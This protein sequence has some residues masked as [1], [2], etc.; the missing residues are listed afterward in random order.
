M[1]LAEA[2]RELTQTGELRP[3]ARRAITRFIEQ[4]DHWENMGRMMDHA[5]LAQIILDES[6]YSAMWQN[7][8][9]PQAQGRLENLKEL[10][11]FMEEFENMQGFLEHVSLVM[12]AEESGEGEKVSLMTLHAAKG[13]EFANVFLPGWE[14]GLFPHQRALDEAGEAG[15]EEERR[16]AYVGITRARRRL[17]IS[18]ARARQIHGRWQMAA[19]SRFIDEL[20]GEHVEIAESLAPIAADR[21]SVSSRMARRGTG[22]GNGSRSQRRET[23]I[24]GRAREIGTKHKKNHDFKIGDRI[25]HNKFGPGEVMEVDGD[26]LTIEFDRAGEKKVVASFVEKG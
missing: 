13:L 5:E 9:S 20:P 14:E 2:A 11:R 12:D 23:V 18:F 19:P 26:K 21:A 10:V 4:L 8:K 24:E 15:L 7:D 22:G 16:L 3:A 1:P 17:E 25:F 6:G